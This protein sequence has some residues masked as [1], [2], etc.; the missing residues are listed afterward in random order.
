MPDLEMERGAL[1]MGKRSVSPG[2]KY[3]QSINFTPSRG[4]RG[5]IRSLTKVFGAE[6]A[7][8]IFDH[9]LGIEGRP[10]DFYEFM[11]SDPE[12]SRCLSESFD[13]EI[14]KNEC[15][16]ISE[17]KKYFGNSILEVGCNNGYITGFL[18]QLFPDARIVAIDRSTNALRIAKERMMKMGIQNVEFLNCTPEELNDKFDTVLSM[19][20][21]RENMISEA[22]PFY[23]E[24]LFLQIECYKE[25]TEKY[26]E[27][28]VTRLN[29]NGTLLAFERIQ[30]D[31]LLCGWWFQL[32]SKKCGPVLE[33][34][35]KY[36]CE[37]ADETNEFQAFVAKM[38]QQNDDV[39]LLHFWYEAI[40]VDPKG[41]NE[42]E[43]WNALV[44]LQDN[45]GKLI[46]G[47]YVM[48]RDDEIVGRFA[49]FE[50]KDEKDLLYYLDATGGQKVRM[51]GLNSSRINEAYDRLQQTIAVNVRDGLTYREIDEK[52]DVVE[53]V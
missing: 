31:A 23:G 18:A 12:I 30:N 16:F 39:E 14:L 35:K 46:R 43:G 3:L 32:N 41:K 49:I 9:L 10:V 52:V 19:R 34:R 40:M 20:T 28:L 21:V 11:N 33:T 24:P 37:E 8:T 29:E 26:T 2:V 22:E 17:N 53:R 36:L 15:N 7:E 6:K 48:D 38:G 13:G 50:D 1:N 5:L 45:A 47:I 25:L 51:Y 4:Q 42:L 44:Y 27:A